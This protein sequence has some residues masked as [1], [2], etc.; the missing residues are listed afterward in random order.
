MVV[1]ACYYTFLETCQHFLHLHFLVISSTPLEITDVE[2]VENTGCSYR[3]ILIFNIRYNWEETILGPF[4][5][6]YIY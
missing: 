3:L 5:C 2:S 4:P 6:M 1:V